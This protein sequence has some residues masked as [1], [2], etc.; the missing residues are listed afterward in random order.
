MQSD[1]SAIIPILRSHPSY[2][3]DV[4]EFWV[5]YGINAEYISNA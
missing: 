2:C 5:N 4:W 1:N 3:S